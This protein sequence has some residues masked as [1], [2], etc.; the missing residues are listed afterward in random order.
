MKKGAQIAEADDQEFDPLPKFVK[1]GI[2]FL[3]SNLADVFI[4]LFG[5]LAGV[6]INVLIG[7]AQFNN[8]VYHPTVTFGW[9][10]VRDVSNMFFIAVL[11]II[12]FGTILRLET[13]SYKRLL[14]HLVVFAVLI[15]FSKTISGLLIGLSQVVMLTFV[16]A[17]AGAGGAS[18]VV[19]L[20]LGDLPMLIVVPLPTRQISCSHPLFLRF[21][22]CCYW[23]LRLLSCF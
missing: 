5:Y 18:F 13:Y 6:L 8:F 10:I 1:E 2:W 20:G 19:A 4:N 11:L 9:V 3:M 21:S 16:K 22:P 15:N 17:F 14:P 7:F 23:Q 12:A